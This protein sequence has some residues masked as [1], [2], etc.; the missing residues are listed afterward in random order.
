M[1]NDDV[2]NAD[3]RGR[4]E[5]V[6]DILA[7]IL[8]KDGSFNEEFGALLTKYL[9]ED[10][11]HVAS[12]RGIDLS[13]RMDEP[14]YRPRTEY[15]DPAEPYAYDRDGRDFDRR[16][17][18]RMPEDVRYMYREA[19]ADAQRPEFTSNG[20]VRYPAMG[21]GDSEERVVY[22]A[23]WEERARQEAARLQRVREDR[24]LRGDSTYV[25]SFVANGRPMR[26]PGRSPLI[27]PLSADD[28]FD[29]VYRNDR[30]RQ[31]D[32]SSFFQEGPPVTK[33]RNR[34]GRQNAAD[35]AGGRTRRRAAYA[36]SPEE[37]VFDSFSDA[38]E[39]EQTARAAWLQPDEGNEAGRRRRNERRRGQRNQI[40]STLRDDYDR[41][42]VLREDEGGRP[43]RYAA[44]EETL[45]QPPRAKRPPEPEKPEETAP[46]VDPEELTRTARETEGLR[47]TV[48]EI[49][50]KYNKRSE[51]EIEAQE[52]ALREKLARQE[53]ERI[54]RENFLKN[55][56]P[57]LA[58]A[59][60]EENADEAAF[61]YDDFSGACPGDS[62]YPSDPLRA[63][64]LAHTA[65]QEPEDFESLDADAQETAPA[66]TEAQGTEP[67]DPGAPETEAQETAPDAAAD[68][69]APEE[70]P[71]AEAP[72]KESPDGAPAEEAPG[73]ADTPSPDSPGEGPASPEGESGAAPTPVDYSIYLDAIDTPEGYDDFSAI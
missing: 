65:A 22:D 73:E 36:A 32:R 69:T 55:L 58:E 51:E 33:A 35:G 46:R 59:L 9:G 31:D 50:D 62:P 54:A 68:E 56:P 63:F 3:S 47:T 64:T 26:G 61:A 23:E 40:T 24:M 2:K 57:E 37:D 48:A 11:A 6:D 4:D 42:S 30:R 17:G 25:R 19:A 52:R 12:L 44:E 5:S 16:I 67:D 13:D 27:D 41:M 43:V 7:G 15:R 20:G 49:V 53:A 45:T 29:D 8:N 66:E 70:I 10:A 21:I 38:Y 18:E 60:K 71:D 72:D 28:D 34:A 1:A 39:S 14:R